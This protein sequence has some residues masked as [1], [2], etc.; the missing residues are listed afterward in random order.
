MN[1]LL[2]KMLLN[3]FPYYPSKTIAISYAA[4]LNIAY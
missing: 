3:K 2:I 4:A 1:Y